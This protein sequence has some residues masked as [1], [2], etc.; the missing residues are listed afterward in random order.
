MPSTPFTA[1][2]KRPR[3]C[4]EEENAT[5]GRSATPSAPS[6]IRSLVQSGLGLLR[7]V[8][9]F[10]AD[11]AKEDWTHMEQPE[12]IPAPVAS[13]LEDGL[14]TGISAEEYRAALKLLL[15]D[16]SD[17]RVEGESAHAA[18]SCASRTSHP[19]F[20]FRKSSSSLSLMSSASRNLY[21]LLEQDD[22]QNSDRLDGAW[23]GDDT[24]GSVAQEAWGDLGTSGERAVNIAG[25]V[26][27]RL[28]DTRCT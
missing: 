3:P 5:N 11:E 4:E 9:S 14:T 18:P 6:G 13:N 21:P 10:S 7:R 22:E 1:S 15:T 25:R 17:G 27:R 2:R 8:A 26:K 28:V 16:D 12:I 20:C 23:N 24:M 19:T